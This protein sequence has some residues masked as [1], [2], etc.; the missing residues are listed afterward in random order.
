MKRIK[1]VDVSDLRLWEKNP[2]VE[3]SIDQMDE[4]NKIY[5]FSAPSQSTSKR[6]L[7]NLASSIAENGY[8][9]EAEPILATRAGDK[10]VIHDANRRLS[11]I[12]LLQHPDRYRELLDDQDYKKLKNL[13]AE[14]PQ[15]IPSS[16]DIVVFGDDEQDKLKEILNRKHNG[17][18][19]GAGTIPWS[20][21][22]KARFSGKQTFSDKLE[23]PFQN[24]F[25]DSLT[26][27]LGGSNAMTSTRRVFNSAPVRKYLDI[28]NPDIITPEQL[29]KVKEVADAVKGYCQENGTLISRLK[30]D[31]IK[32][33]I[34][35]PL[36]EKGQE[37]VWSPGLAAKRLN[38]D[39]ASKFATNRDRHL[40]ARYNNP[41]WMID[42][43]EF[44]DTNLMLAALNAYG[45]LKGDEIERL[46]KAYLI[47]PAIR[48]IYELS[49]L[50]LVKSG[51]EITDTE[52]PIEVSRKHKEHVS[53]VHSLF[54]DGKF[55]NYLQAGRIIFDTFNEAQSVIEHTDFGESVEYSSLMS[56]KSMKDC[57]IDTII[58]LSNDAVLFA[59]LCQQYVQFKK[60]SV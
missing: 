4:L 5:N 41:E 2:R 57:D 32:Q 34:I 25:G 11:A 30:S 35:I 60:Q 51:I 23:T 36:Q 24:Q 27:Y 15:N 53:H 38:H 3:P 52:T 12:K 21:E 44:E 19:D 58:R 55:Q 7:M 14:Y 56:H 28:K 50:A 45:V 1:N 42:A 46:A 59:M 39:F 29:D 48:V 6:Q 37:S 13:V 22:A 33:D 8:Q 9:N 31:D 47:A 49:L 54:K 43:P 26:S 17:P 10:Y 40:G 16:L 18:Q 20:T